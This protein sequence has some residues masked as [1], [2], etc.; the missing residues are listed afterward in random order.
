MARY[1]GIIIFWTLFIIFAGISVYFR[2]QHVVSVR[3]Y[4]VDDSV[5]F[6]DKQVLIKEITLQNFKFSGNGWP[7]WYDN[8][9]MYLP[10]RLQI[11]FAETC[12]FYSRPYKFDSQLGTLKVEGIIIYPSVADVGDYSTNPKRHVEFAINDATSE[13]E[14]ETYI[15]GSNFIYLEDSFPCR[16]DVGSFNLTVTDASQAAK[17]FTIKPSWTIDTYTFSR[18]PIQGGFPMA[19]GQTA[20][21]SAYKARGLLMSGFPYYEGSCLGRQYVFSYT[22]DY[23]T[24]MSKDAPTVARQKIYLI[25]Q[26]GVWRVIDTGP[27]IWLT[28]AG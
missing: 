17:T 6:K 16:M 7:T 13:S 2:F 27:L 21:R 11:P 24:S 23:S 9:V 25:D 1:K 4:E 3:S 22:F 14:F 18:P 26:N 20:F 19:I 28:K 10:P 15:D 12:G 5:S 8:L